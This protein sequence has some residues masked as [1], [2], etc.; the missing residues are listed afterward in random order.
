MSYRLGLIAPARLQLLIDFEAP[1]PLDIIVATALLYSLLGYS[2]FAGI[3]AIGVI[4]PLNSW[5]SKKTAKIMKEL[6]VTKGE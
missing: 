2:A 1:A 6:N 4:I 5:L 3:L